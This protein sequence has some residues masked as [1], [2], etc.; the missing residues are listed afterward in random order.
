[1]RDWLERLRQA[2]CDDGADIQRPAEADGAPSDKVS[3]RDERIAALKAAL[4]E[5]LPEP[6]ERDDDERARALLASMLG[7]FRQEEKNAWWEHFRLRDLPQDE[8]LDEREMLAELQFVEELPKQGRQKNV[9]RVFRFA[10]QETAVKAGDKVHYTAHEDPAEE[11]KTTKLDVEHIDYGARLVTFSMPAAAAAQPPSA[12]LTDQ[13]VPAVKLEQSL[14]AFAEHVRDHGFD[15]AEP[16]AA[17]AELLR[18]RP[19]RRGA[20]TGEALRQPNESTLDATRRLCLELEHGV[21]P[22]QGPPGAG[23]TFTGARAI[24]A[25]AQAG[26]TVGITAVSHKVIENLL[27]GIAAAA[28]EADVDLRL[29]HKDKGEGPAGIEHLNDNGEALAAIGPGAV[30]GATAWTWSRDDAIGAVDYLFVDEAGQMALA[31][32]LAVARAARNLVLLGDPQQLE[33]PSRGAHPDGA[34]VAALV[35]CVGPDRATIADD[36]GLF[37]DTTW[38]LPPPIC[39]FTSELY[40]DGKLTFQ[41]D[42]ERQRLD[43][44]DLADGADLFL[45]EV[46]HHGNQASAPEEVAAITAMLREILAKDATW[47]GRDGKRRAL[48]TDDVMVIAPYNA[49]VGAL[50]RALEPLGVTAVGTVDKFQGQEAPLVIYSC[51]SSTAVDAP[52]GMS[53]LYDPH[54][55][56]VASSRAQGAFVM[57]ASPALFTPEVHS[58]TE[59]RMA[60]GMCRFREVAVRLGEG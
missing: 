24:V 4:V 50:R 3:A 41:P 35:H 57:V 60:N 19:P 20:R 18:R 34:D 32:T 7:Y 13:V 9:R 47:T 36:R 49:Q 15:D 51:T 16:F 37:L 55:L 10:P 56:N 33:Q 17:A 30:V 43:G 21:L 58:P 5:G 28:R 1:L 26:R 14:L 53:F 44:I 8:Q 25:L 27:T 46:S 39:A 45:R 31:Q 54:R 6:D 48:T 42:C 29:V 22:I 23:K 38:R 11:P 40:Y 12:V 59:M 52:R 2:A